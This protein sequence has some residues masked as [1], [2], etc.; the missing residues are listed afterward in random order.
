MLRFTWKLLSALAIAAPCAAATFTVTSSADTAGS[1]CAASCT[2]RQA[3]TAANANA[4]SDSISFNVA[5]GG[6]E[7]LIQP[8]TPL[9]LITQPLVIDG[10]TQPGASANTAVSG[11]NAQL[12]IRLH[13][14]AIAT[15]L[16]AGFSACASAV[17]IRGFSITGFTT[18]SSAAIRSG[19]GGCAIAAQVSVRGNFVGLRTDGVTADANFSGV[20]ANG[21][22]VHVGSADLADR[23]VIGST[24]QE[25]IVLFNAGVSGSSVSNNL[26]GSTRLGDS[27]RP[28]GKGIALGLFVNNV[29]I[30]SLAAP[31]VIANVGN[32]VGVLVG[33]GS[34]NVA[35][36]NRFHGVSLPVDLIL[37][38]VGTVTANDL[39]DID[40]GPNGLQNFPVIQSVQRI[41]GGVRVQGT[42]DVPIASNN[43]LYTLSFYANTACAASGN[44]PGERFLG[45]FPANFT[46]GSGESFSIDVLTQDLLPTGTVLTA[47]VTGPEGSSE[48]SAC[49][50][51]P[52]GTAGFVVTTPGVATGSSC[53]GACTL[54]QAIN[55][56]N[57]RAGTDTVAFHLPG[58]GAHLVG[59]NSLPVLKSDLI[60]D[61]Y[62]QPGAAVNTDPLRS[63]AQIKIEL[64]TDV[65]FGGLFTCGSNITVRGLALTGRQ[66][67]TTKFDPLTFSCAVFGTNVRLLGSFVGIRPDGS[68][69][70]TTGGFVSI[71]DTVAIIGTA[72]PADRN[73]LG[74]APAAVSLSGAVAGT[75]IQGN[76]IGTDP[77]GLQNRGSTIGIQLGNGATGAH[78]GGSG[79]QANLI[80]FN[81]VGIA[82]FSSAGTGNRLFGNHFSANTALGI[83]LSTQPTN[84]DGI[85]AN[86]LN[87]ADTGAN[88]LQNFPV[89]SAASQIGNSLRID[90]QLDV[91]VATSNAI[92]TLAFYESASC[93][94]SG[95]GEG[96]IFLGTQTVSLSGGA[97]SFSVTLPIAPNPQALQITATATDPSGNTSEFSA[98][99][100][101][102]ALPEIIFQS[103]FE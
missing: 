77:T 75:L 53:G 72:A 34:N 5:N 84:G 32:G 3:I 36:A 86:D 14:A 11:S 15:T 63:N 13:G 85:T 16:V 82:A 95:N 76:L 12:R 45:S 4:D 24:T 89:L 9:P 65:N 93:D 66:A 64:F 30:G 103:R 25:A 90:G 1:T 91:P 73:V 17:S 92:Y 100:L 98:C 22:I 79:A 51:V 31:N 81:G 7:V 88:L 87:D 28:V 20:E 99:R 29:T 62:T 97:E 59:V 18:T 47:A 52:A 70:P 69:P 27:A 94:A 55:A 40:T 61:G 83:D 67:L 74:L 102:T 37:G 19:G 43:A 42:L 6:G 23:N 41:A 49:A 48:F 50:A 78:I 26:I 57:A 46:Q 39:D 44:G 71:N 33:A 58:S 56:A 10:Y 8:A 2:L 35:T 96:E 101:A 21:A 68:L 38:P 60:L 54:S 80:A